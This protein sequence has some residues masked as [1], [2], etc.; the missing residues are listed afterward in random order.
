MLRARRP[1]RVGD[2]D[3]GL[4]VRERLPVRHEPDAKTVFGGQV[5]QR[6][7]PVVEVLVQNV[8]LRAVGPVG[9]EIEEP[10]GAITRPTWRGIR[11]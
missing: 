3:L 9:G 2:A 1:A 7:R 10:P 11:R 5:D 6:L 8:M 4:L